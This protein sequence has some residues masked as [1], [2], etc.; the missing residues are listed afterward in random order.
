M[1]HPARRTTDNETRARDA[2]INELARREILR[3][4]G[5]RDPGENLEQAAAL[6]TVSFALRDAF[7]DARR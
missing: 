5:E 1:D 7:A 6:I 4:D 3:R 2:E